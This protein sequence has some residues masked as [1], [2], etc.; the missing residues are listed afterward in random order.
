[1][2]GSEEFYSYWNKVSQLF[3]T[4]N[5]K[6]GNQS[7]IVTVHYTTPNGND[8]NAYSWI[9]FHNTHTQ[10]RL[11]N[12]DPDPNPNLIKYK[13]NLTQSGFNYPNDIH[14]TSMPS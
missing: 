13:Q 4:L 3:V 14:C 5:E 10:T 2:T 8:D 7:T 12:L 6:I 9:G 1:M 11:K